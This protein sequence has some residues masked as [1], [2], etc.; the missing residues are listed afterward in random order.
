M[1][2][3]RWSWWRWG[4]IALSLISLI[5]GVGSI[6]L[7]GP[8]LAQDVDAAS[9]LPR[10]SAPDAPV[11]IGQAQAPATIGRDQAPLPLSQV[12]GTPIDQFQPAFAD[13]APDH[14]AYEAVTRLYY[15]GIMSGY[16]AP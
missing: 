13:V 1:T 15:S 5:S 3:N 10:F 4:A 6:G 14:W 12:Y 7:V 8:A 2:S 11:V 9:A 16:P